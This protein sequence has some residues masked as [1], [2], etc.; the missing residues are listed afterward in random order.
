M[1]NDL[2]LNGSKRAHIAICSAATQRLLL[3]LL[4]KTTTHRIMVAARRTGLGHL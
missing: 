1:M 4:L 2:T 3:L